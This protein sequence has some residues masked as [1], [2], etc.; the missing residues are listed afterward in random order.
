MILGKLA[1]FLAV[2]HSALGLVLLRISFMFLYVLISQSN[3]LP[4][5]EKRKIEVSK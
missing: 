1:E 2:S 5:C 3:V 4:R